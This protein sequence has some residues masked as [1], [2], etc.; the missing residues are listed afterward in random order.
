MLSCEKTI[1]NC[2]D[3]LVFAK[4]E[5]EKAKLENQIELTKIHMKDLIEEKKGLEKKAIHIR[6]VNEFIELEKK[7]TSLERGIK[8]ENDILQKNKKSFESIKIALV[9]ALISRKTLA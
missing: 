6:Q 1:N 4:T 2:Y 7:L 9:K 3:S 5:V 8:K